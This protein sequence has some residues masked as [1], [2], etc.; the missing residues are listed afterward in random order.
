MSNQQLGFMG[1]AGRLGQWT[2]SKR[3]GK[4]L[5]R[6]VPVG[7]RTK[8]EAQ[9]KVQRT[10]RSAAAYAKEMP[11]TPA[12]L[13]RYEVVAEIRRTSAYQAAMADYL[14]AP[15]IEKIDLDGFTGAAGGRIVVDARD[16][17]DVM[18]VMVEVHGQDGTLLE[19]GA[20]AMENAMWVYATT[21][22]HP[23][24]TPVTITATAADRPGNKATKMVT[25]G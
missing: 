6:Q 11:K 20:A 1:Y 9:A 21:V 16:D 7:K 17:V 8:T 12:L 19:K 24:G 18:S 5:V 3:N 4:V 25:W 13:A 14:R 15:W 10:F 22:A 2:F 23:A